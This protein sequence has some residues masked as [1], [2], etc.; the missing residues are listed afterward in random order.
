MTKALFSPSSFS[1]LMYIVVTKLFFEII[2]NRSQYNSC[3]GRHLKGYHRGD[4]PY[5][6][7][8]ASRYSYSISSSKHSACRSL[9][10][11]LVQITSVSRSASYSMVSKDWPTILLWISLQ[12]GTIWTGSFRRPCLYGCFYSRRVLWT[13]CFWTDSFSAMT[14]TKTVQVVARSVS[15]MLLAC[16][17]WVQQ[18]TR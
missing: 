11:S 17:P 7:V 4:L 13:R 5:A 6:V 14:T 2:I 16:L 18:A 10:A 9:L 12:G 15:E 8:I 3:K 1:R